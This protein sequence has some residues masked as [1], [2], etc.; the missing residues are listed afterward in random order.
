VVQL[1]YARVWVG[2]LLR[3]YYAQIDMFYKV[4]V[5]DILVSDET[6]P[7]IAHKADGKVERIMKGDKIPNWLAGWLAGLVALTCTHPSVPKSNSSSSLVVAVAM[8]TW[9]TSYGLLMAL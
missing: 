2:C 7:S 5:S 3:K 6:T 8:T 4:V 9:S 1:G